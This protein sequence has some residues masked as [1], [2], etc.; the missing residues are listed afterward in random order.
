MG[1][2]KGRWRVVDLELFY[3]LNVIKILISDPVI[4]Y[5]ATTNKGNDYTSFLHLNLS[6]FKKNEMKIFFIICVEN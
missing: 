5:D 1:E 2:K 3:N 4:E 6:K